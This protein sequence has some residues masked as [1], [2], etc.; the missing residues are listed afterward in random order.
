MAS[1][2]VLAMKID[3]QTVVQAVALSILALTLSGCR[4]LGPSAEQKTA[5]AALL[6][7]SEACVRDVRDMKVRYESSRH[8][9]A[10]GA[11]SGQYIDAG[12]GRPGAPLETEIE[13]ER[14]RV[15]AWMALALSSSKGE[16]NRIW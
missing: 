6:V 16:A 10:L 13:F 3:P 8:C 12:G 5:S 1:A 9:N 7:A 11:L 2:R 15:H 14:A 4:F